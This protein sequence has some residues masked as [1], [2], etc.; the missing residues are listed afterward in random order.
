MTSLEA[1]ALRKALPSDISDIVDTQFRAFTDDF[2][3][4]VFMGPDTRGGHERLQDR[5]STTM[6]EDFSDIWIKVTDEASGTIVAASNWK[7]HLN[8]VPKHESDFDS[9]WLE[10]DPEKLKRAEAV[11][12]GLVETRKRLMTEPFV[13]GCFCV[14]CTVEMLTAYPPLQNCTSVLQ[15]Q[16]ISAGGLVPLCSSGAVMLQT[17]LVSQHGSRLR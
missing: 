16:P 4:D 9:F 5:Y 12:D 13:R 6:R 7:I 14:P 15:I 3:R 11:L 10:D 17:D 8:S 1:F 2:V